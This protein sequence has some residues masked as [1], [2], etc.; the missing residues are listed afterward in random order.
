[1]ICLN[2]YITVCQ[3]SICSG[4]EVPILDNRI[5]H[6]GQY[7]AIVGLILWE[8][9]T[10]VALDK[11]LTSWNT[12]YTHIIQQVIWLISVK[13]VVLS[14]YTSTTDL[15]DARGT[16]NKTWRMLTCLIWPKLSTANL[17]LSYLTCWSTNFADC[18]VFDSVFD[19]PSKYLQNQW[20]NKCIKFGK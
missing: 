9:I 7:K 15:T 1:M 10:V 11:L 14:P 17:V 12:T 13:W 3:K 6:N 18:L 8:N 4:I 16:I 5:A 20:I 19:A 2:K